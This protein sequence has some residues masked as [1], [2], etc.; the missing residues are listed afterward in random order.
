MCGTPKCRASTT[1]WV[2]LP[3]PGAPSRTRRT[4]NYRAKLHAVFDA[5]ASADFLV[6]DKDAAVAAVQRAFGFMAPK[7]RWSHGDAGAGFRVTFCRPNPS[8]VQSPTLIEL[9]EPAPLD[10]QR[11]LGEVVPNVQGLA[12]MQRDRPLRTH[13]A[14]IASS[15]VAD[16]VESVRSKGVRHWVQPGRPGFPFLRLWIGITAESLAGYQPDDDGGL[17]LEVVDTVTLGLPADALYTD[18]PAPEGRMVRTLS[19]GFLVED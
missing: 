3:A 19:R 8:L 4:G 13:G 11:P 14:P 7:P 6:S 1:P 16:L 18:P 5:L 15:H 9:I 17:M 12:E 10:S 2:P